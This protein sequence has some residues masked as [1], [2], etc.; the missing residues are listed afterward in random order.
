MSQKVSV[1][2]KL[3]KTICMP[4]D[5]VQKIGAI[6]YGGAIFSAGT[7]QFFVGINKYILNRSELVEMDETY[8]CCT[9]RWAP[10]RSL[11]PGGI[12]S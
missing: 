8:T 2:K 7:V 9:C 10:R 6:F 4:G 11:Y 12:S 1:K 3:L 5:L